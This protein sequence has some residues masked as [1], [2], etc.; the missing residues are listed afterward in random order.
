MDK[1]C[2]V[3][4]WTKSLGAWVAQL[5]G[6]ELSLPECWYSPTPSWVTLFCGCVIHYS[7]HD[8]LQTSLC[9]HLCTSLLLLS[10]D[11][12]PPSASPSSITWAVPVS[13]C[14]SRGQQSQAHDDNKS[15]L[16]FG[17]RSSETN[18]RLWSY[19][20]WSENSDPPNE[21]NKMFCSAG[22]AW[23]NYCTWWPN[24]RNSHWRLGFVE[25]N[26]KS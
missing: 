4:L 7:S 10:P 14:I 11:P 18:S 2:E 19:I 21:P 15:F 24:L 20:T 16:F 1:I 6:P 25:N 9:G 26:S 5:T 22:S 12:S 8:S 3:G 13:H 23:K 17:E